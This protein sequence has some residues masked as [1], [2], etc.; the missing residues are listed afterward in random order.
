MTSEEYGLN[1]SRFSKNSRFIEVRQHALVPT[2]A[3]REYQD[4]GWIMLIMI[5]GSSKISFLLAIGE[6]VSAGWREKCVTGLSM[7]KAI[8][9]A[10]L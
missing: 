5:P 6:S 9:F 4:I 2:F 8:N 1:V 7:K 3:E 10:S